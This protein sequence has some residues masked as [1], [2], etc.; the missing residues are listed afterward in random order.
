MR[1]NANDASARYSPWRRSAG[2]V[3]RKPSG[4]ANAAASTKP[5]GLPLPNGAHWYIANAP[6]PANVIWASDT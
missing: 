3:M 1:A 6:A 5:T 2:S 4:I